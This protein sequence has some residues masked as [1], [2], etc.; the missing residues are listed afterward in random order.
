MLTMNLTDVRAHLSDLADEVVKT[1][2]RITI[3]RNGSPEMVLL[4]LEEYEGFLETL[5]ILRDPQA[6]ANLRQAQEEYVRGETYSL[7]E[8]NLAMA[9][10]RAREDYER[11]VSE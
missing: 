4:S 7:E 5:E 3:T 6:V 10:R 2:E 11:R 8:L 9:Q 1:H